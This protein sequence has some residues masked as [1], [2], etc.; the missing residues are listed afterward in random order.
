M[1]RFR[2]VVVRRFIEGKVFGIKLV[3]VLGLI[4][5][6]GY[7]FKSRGMLVG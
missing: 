4:S 5:L 2:V 1:F 3:E 7:S 6:S